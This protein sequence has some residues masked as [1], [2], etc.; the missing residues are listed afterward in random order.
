[1]QTIGRAGAERGRT[2]A[3]VRRQED[4]GDAKAIA[5]TDRRREIQLAYNREHGITPE[6][7]QEGDLRH[8]RVPLDGVAREPRPAPAPPDQS[9]DGIPMTREQLEKVVVELEEEMLA[10][11][12]ARSRRLGGFATSSRSCAA[13]SRR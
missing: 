9:T 3:H 7:V 6:T 1:M 12:G 13:T 5:E 8:R 10:A 4:R 2:G 11:A